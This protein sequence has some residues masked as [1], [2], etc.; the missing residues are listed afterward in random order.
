MALKWASIAG[1]VILVLALLALIARHAIFANSPA[2]IAAQVLAGLLMLWARLTFGLRS[3]HAAANPTQGGLV[4]TGPYRYLRHPIYAAVLLFLSAAVLSHLSP[5]NAFLV[6]VAAI[7]VAMRIFA[8][9]CLLAERYPDYAAYAA[10]TK[11]V[12]P[13]LL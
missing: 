11:R 7:A 9:E 1:Y 2:T 10:R 4:T 12:I 3:F 8:E 5:L 6:L 13:F